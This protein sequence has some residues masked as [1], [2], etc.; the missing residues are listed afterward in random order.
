MTNFMNDNLYLKLKKDYDEI[1]NFLE[2]KGY[3][4]PK[5]PKENEAIKDEGE[6]LVKS[7][8]IQGLLKYHGLANKFDRIS[9][10]P[11]ISLNNSSSFT[12]SYLKLSHDLSEDIAILN[13]SLLTSNNFDRFLNAL[14]FFRK[15]AKFKTKVFLYSKNFIDSEKSNLSGKGLGTSASGSSALGLAM[16]SIIYGN[17]ENYV[18]NYRLISIFSRY[19]SGSGC[20]SATGG[21]SL[22]MSHPGATTLESFALRLDR[23]EH[24]KFIKNIALITIPIKSRLKTENFHDLAPYSPFFKPWLKN[25]KEMVFKFIE[26][27]DNHDLNSIGELS[28]FDT[29]CLN[30]VSSTSIKGKVQILWKP[31]TLEIISKVLDLR[32][33]S[34]NVYF[35]I[36]TGPS[37]VILTTKKEVSE[38]MKYLKSSIQNIDLIKGNI[39]GPPEV[40]NFESKLSRNFLN[41]MN[42]YLKELFS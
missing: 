18:K 8:S 33:S 21:I 9:F 25:R 17:N 39:A 27:L 40:L 36:D 3:E 6:C 38:I 11:S 15:Y 4:I 29:M 14:K 10:F 41:E 42:L 20:R 24:E 7:Y 30:G 12:I 35:S 34:Y 1:L 28:E 19:L 13:N 37:V 32:E 22:W 31:K 5:I 23:R 16:I 26:A 2:K